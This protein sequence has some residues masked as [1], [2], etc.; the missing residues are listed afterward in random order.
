[1][2]LLGERSIERL[3]RAVVSGRI[4]PYLA[5][6]TLVVAVVAGL[7]ARLLAPRAFDSLGDAL[8]WSAA[9]VTTIGYGDVVPTT[10]GGRVVGVFVMMF[11]V[12]A[13]S[14]ITALVTAV[15]IAYQQRKLGLDAA[16]H[17]EVLAALE[18]VEHRL[19]ALERQR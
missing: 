17:E 7:A 6:M 11:G 10:T 2:Q 18:R 15:F 13:V 9:T 19:D 3:N 12:A 8:W 16:R 4:I 14:V 5:L 1:M